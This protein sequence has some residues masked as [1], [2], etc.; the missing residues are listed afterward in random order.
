M[1]TRPANSS[2]VHIFDLAEQAGFGILTSRWSGAGEDTSQ[3]VRN[4]TRAGAGLSLVGRLSAGTSKDSGACLTAYTTPNGLSIMAPAL[5]HLPLA[6]P[7]S[8][9]II[10]VPNVS[11]VGEAF[12]L[13]PSMAALTTVVPLLPEGVVVL[14][15]SRPQETVDF[16]AL[17]YALKSSHVIHIF[18][19]FSS[20]RENGSRLTPPTHYLHQ[21]LP[22]LLEEAGYVHFDYTGDESPQSVFVL[23]NGPLALIAQAVARRTPGLGVVTVNVLRP[24]NEEALMDIIPSSAVHVHVLDEVPN[25]SAPGI[26]HGE[27]FG[28]LVDS[29]HPSA[30]HTLR[31]TPSKT[32]EY[33]TNAAAFG[34]ILVKSLPSSP[35]S[36]S[37]LRPPKS[38]RVLLL[39]EPRSPAALVPGVIQLFFL[40]APSAISSRLLASHDVFSKAGGIAINQLLLSPA[41]ELDEHLPLPTALPIVGAASEGTVDFLAILDQS[42][43]KSHSVLGYAV[44]EAPVLVVTTWT[45]E[46]LAANLPQEAVQLVIDHNLR[47][48]AFNAKDAAETLAGDSG[49][50]LNVLQNI[51]IHLA[52]VRLYLG[53]KASESLVLN[54]SQ[55]IFSASGI[56]PA[57]F[58]KINARAWTALQ[59][60]ETY[61]PLPADAPPAAHQKAIDFNAIAVEGIDGETVVNGARLASWHDAAKHLLFPLAFAPDAVDTSDELSPSNPALRPEV[62]D[63]TFLVTCKVNRRLTPREYDRNVFHLEFDSSGTG[64]KY[65][66][67]EALGVHGWND[68]G[69]IRDFCEW[70]GVNPALLVTLPIPGSE[71]EEPKYHTRTVFQALEQQIDIFGR[72]P[73]SFYTDL[74][75]YATT[76][77]DRHA[78][79]FIG[80]ADG[81]STFKKFSEKDTLTFAD[82]LRM[83]PSARP[84]IETLCILIGD[85]K[86]RHYSIA[87]AQSVVGDRI[88]LLVVTVDWVTPTGTWTSQRRKMLLIVC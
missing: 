78:L 37:S 65:E 62:P 22:S 79:L 16:T 75:A 58:R 88:D 34:Q 48:F 54:V 74:A 82:V 52:F 9:L 40:S 39:A 30:V 6:T 72:P 57:F 60:V 12:S 51:L 56:D 26:L 49:Q 27:V 38:K 87:S 45:P 19:Q 66:I 61:P 28:T 77:L 44:H 3:V 32:L 76:S 50:S 71:G 64:L 43:L 13:S 68:E 84:G 18:D 21:D 11:A 36:A 46:E 59:Q 41:R 53:S 42:L 69:E 47:L 81:A 24:W 31:I 86:P 85:I 70:Y 25:H 83:Y 1:S 29:A 80:S 23:L 5:A 14:L 67:G 15:S 20:A 55:D 7:T 4:Q 33:I 35:P 63:T 8:R 10:Q 73:K 17:A 2:T